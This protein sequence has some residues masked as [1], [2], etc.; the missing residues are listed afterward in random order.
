MPFAGNASALYTF[1]ASRNNS[2]E[3]KTV[4]SDFTAHRAENWEKSTLRRKEERI[5]APDKLFH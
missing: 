4:A 2:A 1:P 3:E 5:H